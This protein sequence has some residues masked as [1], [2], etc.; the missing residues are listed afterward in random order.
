[1]QNYKLK[2]IN[3]YVHVVINVGYSS[4]AKTGNAEYDMLLFRGQLVK[5][6]IGKKIRVIVH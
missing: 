2:N 3:S 6:S 4:T 1:M 5:I